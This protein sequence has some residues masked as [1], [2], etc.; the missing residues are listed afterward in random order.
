MALGEV[1]FDD[2]SYGGADPDPGLM[3]LDY[4]RNKAREFQDVMNQLDATAGALQEAMQLDLPDDARADLQSML[5]DFYAHVGP[6]RL[7]ADSL[8]AAA[9]AVNAFGGRFPVLSVPQRLGVV[10][11]ATVAVVAGA[12]AA[13]AAL[14]TW[15]VQW[16]GG[17]NERMGREQL[18][19]ALPPEQRA[20][21]VG[22]MQRTD[23]A[24]SRATN[25][26]T[27]LA[28]TIKWV[29]IGVAVIFGLRALTE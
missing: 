23:A 12:V 19:N 3:D 27:D 22:L 20:T 8:N 13:A 24:Q 21:M 16:I 6:I 25:P 28:S 18:I 11:L 26:L 29:A 10:P 7:A 5:D 1:A 14:I 2:V 9:E 17:V 4:Y 15:G